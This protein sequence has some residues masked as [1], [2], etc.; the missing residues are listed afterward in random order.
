MATTRRNI[1]AL[2]GFPLFILAIFVLFWIF[3]AD[4]M[5]VIRDREALRA[6]VLGWGWAGFLA[7]ILL[8]VFQV[9]VFVVPGEIVQVAG[10][11]IF[12]LWQSLG[13]SILGIGIGSL[14]NFAAGRILGRPFVVSLF[15]EEKVHH[16][17][18]L[19]EG[20]KAAAGFFLLF[21]IPGI[22]K[23][24][25]CYVAGLTT[26]RFWTFL[27]IS[28][29]GRIPGILGSAWIGDAAQKGD[30]RVAIAIIVV[31]S[32]LFL[33]GLFFRDRIIAWIGRLLHHD[34]AGEKEKPGAG[35]AG[36]GL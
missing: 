22:P 33:L 28:L 8:Q 16:A 27:A 25:L 15:G 36:P 2:V 30:F 34:E 17:E 35:K 13:L 10:G 21:A 7:F 9:V 29:A 4:I 18:K 3:R 31:A 6:W 1:P 26:M 20:G 12:G 11:W 24:V 14:V 5:S 32:V 23:D 19:A